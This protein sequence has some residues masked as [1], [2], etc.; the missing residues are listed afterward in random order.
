M[1][2]CHPYAYL[3]I[4]V[5]MYVYI[6][7]YVVFGTVHLCVKTHGRKTELGRR[8][9]SNKLL[10][11]GAEFRSPPTR[12][13]AA[14]CASG[15][16]CLR[17]VL[18]NTSAVCTSPSLILH[19]DTV[20]IYICVHISGLYNLCIYT[21]I[22]IYIY[23]Y[24][25]CEYNIQICKYTRRCMSMCICTCLCIFICTCTRKSMYMYTYICVGECIHAHLYLHVYTW[26]RAYVCLCI[27][28]SMCMRVDV[29]I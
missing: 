15:Q 4:S 27:C 7:M 16:R 17:R 18:C 25:Y 5:H 1:G 28:V 21:C 3:W 2:A 19:P 10:N 12:T 14:A 13:A 26:I 24:I 8:T 6:Y 23:M 29:Y 20:C 9:Q 11:E 22:C